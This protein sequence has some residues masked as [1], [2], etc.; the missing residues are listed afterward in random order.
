[1]TEI[2]LEKQ[3]EKTLRKI[4]RTKKHQYFLHTCTQEHLLPKFTSIALKVQTTLLLNKFEAKKFQ[5]KILK[6]ALKDQD[7]KFNNLNS[8]LS[9]LY[10]SL[11]KF[12]S[13]S[14]LNTKTNIFNS[15]IEKTENSNDVKRDTKL[16]KLRGDT[17]VTMLL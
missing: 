6:K 1:M 4:Y 8:K 7:T 17:V 5:L 9:L 12:T 11:L 14:E 15:K 16:A 2:T 10:N 3:Y 13:Q